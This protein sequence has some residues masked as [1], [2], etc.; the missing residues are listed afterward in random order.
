MVDGA[1]PLS[2]VRATKGFLDRYTVSLLDQSDLVV[3]LIMFE[4][5]ARAV[6][7]AWFGLVRGMKKNRR[8]CL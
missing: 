3:V 7:L 2:H 6:G 1:V 5:A 8:S 4:I